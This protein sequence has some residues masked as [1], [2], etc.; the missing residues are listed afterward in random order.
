MHLILI[1]FGQAFFWAAMDISVLH[2]SSNHAAG[3]FLF[4]MLVAFFIL[5]CVTMWRDNTPL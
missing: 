4:A 1:A 2:M 3:V 5:C